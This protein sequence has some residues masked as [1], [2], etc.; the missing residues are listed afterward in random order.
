MS[1]SRIDRERSGWVNPLKRPTGPTGRPLCRYCGEEIPDRKRRTFCSEQCVTEHRIRTDPGFVRDQV[2]RRDKGVCACCGFDTTTVP[3]LIYRA[4]LEHPELRQV[5]DGA[6]KHVLRELGIPP[7][8]QTYWDADHVVPVVQG[9][10]TC[11][12]DNYRTLCVPCHQRETARLAAERAHERK[13]AKEQERGSV[14]LPLDQE[15]GR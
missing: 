1:T 11:G 3:A 15:A 4:E 12:L 2:F 13:R 5:W 8:R 9:G 6:R 10:G 7:H 14:R